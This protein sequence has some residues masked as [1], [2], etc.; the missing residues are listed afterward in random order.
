[1][2]SVSVEQAFEC[3]PLRSI[4]VT[5]LLHYYED[6]RLPIDRWA[7]FQLSGCTALP[8]F[9]RSRWDLPSSRLCLGNV[10][11]SLTPVDPPKPWQLASLVLPSA[12]LTASA[13][14]IYSH[15]G[16]QSLHAVALQPITSLCTL[17]QRCY[18]R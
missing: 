1:M 9:R 17:R 10:P 5:L 12:L 6:I 8:L 11:R 7:S 16:A 4:G 3:V 2:G 14:T 13:S 15:H 18:Q